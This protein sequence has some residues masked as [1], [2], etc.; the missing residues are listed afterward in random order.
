MEDISSISSDLGESGSD[1]KSTGESQ[2]VFD[3]TTQATD[4]NTDHRIYKVVVKHKNIL[5]TFVDKEVDF[6]KAKTL[7]GKFKTANDNFFDNDSFWN[8]EITWW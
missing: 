6:S 7:P 4:S 3:T 5:E 2:G 1:H 8:G